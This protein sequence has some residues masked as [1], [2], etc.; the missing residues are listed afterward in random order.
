MELFFSPREFAR[1]CLVSPVVFVKRA[2]ESEFRKVGSSVDVYEVERILSEKSFSSSSEVSSQ[3]LERGIFSKVKE[4][5]SFF[6]GTDIKHGPFRMEIFNVARL[7]RHPYNGT[8]ETRGKKRIVVEGNHFKGE[9][10]GEIFTRIL[11]PFQEWTR[12]VVSTREV[13]LYDEGHF[14]SSNE[15]VFLVQSSVGYY[16][17]KHPLFS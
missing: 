12:E 16:P 9:L 1:F 15:E 14:I 11:I 17:S 2:Q 3:E 6:P 13:S 4:E 10:H 5:T 7:A 8:F